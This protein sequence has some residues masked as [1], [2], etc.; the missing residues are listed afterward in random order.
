MT[1][2]TTY[3]TVPHS[4]VWIVLVITLLLCAFHL[5][6]MLDFYSPR[7]SHLRMNGLYKKYTDM[8]GHNALNSAHLLHW[9]LPWHWIHHRKLIRAI[10]KEVGVGESVY[11]VKLENGVFVYEIYIYHQPTFQK[12]LKEHLS[13]LIGDRKLNLAIDYMKVHPITMGS[14]DL[15]HDTFKKGLSGLSFYRVEGN[16]HDPKFLLFKDEMKE[17]G[18]IALKSS[19]VLYKVQSMREEINKVL[20]TFPSYTHH[21]WVDDTDT[22]CFKR[23]GDIFAIYHC[24]I[25]YRSFVKFLKL[26]N[27]KL[28]QKV[29][30]NRR[31]L[32]HLRFEAVIEYRD[33]VP[34]KYGVVGTF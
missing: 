6:S 10:Q 14:F 15:T 17:D 22:M 31:A 19:Y 7:P 32:E 24:G 9:S 21:D 33:N 8:R 2:M 28:C 18:T 3:I 29:T 5:Y 12:I 27:E 16:E 25:K 26:W 23:K 4:K 20:K 11:A 1:A 34:I 30:L 13:H